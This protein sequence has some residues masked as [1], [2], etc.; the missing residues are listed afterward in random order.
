MDCLKVYNALIHEMKQI[1]IYVQKKV[2][3]DECA[4]HAN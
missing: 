1:T 2:Y 4:F 3:N